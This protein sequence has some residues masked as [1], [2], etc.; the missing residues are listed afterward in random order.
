LASGK[1][2]VDPRHRAFG[3]FGERQEFPPVF[4]QCIAGAPPFEQFRAGRLL[5]RG[6]A[7]HDGRLAE[8]QPPRRAERGAGPGHGQEQPEVVPVEHRPIIQQC[9]TAAQQC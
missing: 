5:E 1:R 3:G 4:G 7:A 9:I 2:V 8:A 6:D